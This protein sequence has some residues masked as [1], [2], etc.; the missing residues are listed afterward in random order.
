[1]TENYRIVPILGVLKEVSR[2]IKGLRV[3]YPQQGNLPWIE[4]I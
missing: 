3:K 2:D 4:K 1:L